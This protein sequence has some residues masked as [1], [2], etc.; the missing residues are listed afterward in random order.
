MNLVKEAQAMQN[1]L[2]ESLM[3]IHENAEIHFQLDKTVAHVVKKLREFGYEPKV[4]GN[5]NVT[6]TVGKGGKT[7][8]MRA[9]MDALPILEDT[10][11]PY[12]S[13]NG[14][15]HACGHDFNTVILLGAAKLL[16]QHESELKGTV[17][18]YFQPAEET[19]SGCIDG[20]KAGIMENPTVDAAIGIH[21]SGGERGK[22]DIFLN[23][24]SLGSCDNYKITIK[25]QNAHGAGPHAGKNAVVTASHIV[26][27]LQ[28][29]VSAE[30]PATGSVTLATCKFVGGTAQN[31]IPDSAELQGTIR[32]LDNELQA[33]MRKRVPEI[34]ENITKAFGMEYEFEWMASVPVMKNNHDMLEDVARYTRDLG[35]NVEIQENYGLASEDF[36]LIS[37]K[38]PSVYLQFAT[39]WHFE[40][41]GPGRGGHT[42]YIVYD[43]E[44]LHTGAAIFANTA[45]R[46]LEE[47]H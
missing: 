9:D 23:K 7:I 46:W 13:K 24:G 11:L 35:M 27:A 16:K 12:A 19:I 40:V 29:I 2:K 39:F 14:N 31:I 42:P 4:I 44:R 3:Y 6:A 8:L 36:S 33:K 41:S 43:I 45:A 17:K 30:I 34:V 18:L 22:D 26:I 47:N 37:D 10:G 32:T 20:I 25:G 1:E 38:V 28:N 15:M 5:N 21:M